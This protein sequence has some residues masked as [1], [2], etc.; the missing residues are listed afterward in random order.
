[1][2]VYLVDAADKKRK[3]D[4]RSK[5]T[6]GAEEREV[7]HSSHQPPTKEVRTSRGLPK[8]STSIG[9]SKEAEGDCLPKPSVWRPIFTLSLGSPVL[10]DANLRDHKNGSLG[11]VAECLEKTLCLPKDMQE[12]RSFKKR[13]EFLSLK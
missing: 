7:T 12:L 13:E 8:K 4:Q 10:S 2:C 1:M 9:T 11:L 3:R 5:G 6:E